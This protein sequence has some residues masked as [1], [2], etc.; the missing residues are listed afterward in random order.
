MQNVI[1]YMTKLAI[2]LGKKCQTHL[3]S[4]YNIQLVPCAMHI[5][6]ASFGT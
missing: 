5:Y 4:L 2:E 1:W 3:P 6:I